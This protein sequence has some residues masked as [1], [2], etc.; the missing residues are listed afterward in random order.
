M[1]NDVKYTLNY[2]ALLLLVFVI[3]LHKELFAPITMIFMLTSIINIKTWQQIKARKNYVFIL[4]LFILYAISLTYTEHLASGLGKLETKLALFF[5]PLGFYLSRLT[6]RAHFGAIARAFVEG[7]FLAGCIS[8]LRSAILTYLTGHY[9]H[10]FY[11][12]FG[13]FHHTSYAAMYACTALIILYYYA[14]KPSRQFHFSPIINFILLVSLSLFVGLLLSRTGL[15]I[16]IL[17]HFSALSYWMIYHKKYLFG[18]LSLLAIA[19]VFSALVLTNKGFN[20]RVMELLDFSKKHEHSASMKRTA[21]WSMN[22]KIGQQHPIFGVGDGDVASH[23]EMAYFEHGSN[24][25]KKHYLNAH[26]QYLQTLVAIG[27][28]GVIA[29]L[30]PYIYLFIHYYINRFWLPIFILSIILIN[31]VTEAMLET[32]SGVAFVSFYLAL[33]WELTHDSNTTSPQTV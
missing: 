10:F 8:L 26:N 20:Q 32:Q 6:V 22:W 30:L 11:D 24:A 9:S 27:W 23:Q 28:L 29:L 3:P 13:L 2:Y 17:I 15:I 33:F 19:G 1:K 18:I 7:V 16:L 12:E 4:L 25:L 31:F 14:F 21:L 5:L